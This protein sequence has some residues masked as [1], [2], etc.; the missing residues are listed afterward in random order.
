MSQNSEETGLQKFMNLAQVPHEDIAERIIEEVKSGNVNPVQMMITI[1]RLAKIVELTTDSQ[2]GDKELR[3]IFK[4]SVALALDGGKSVDMFGANLR[5]QATGTY[6][7][8]EPCKDTVLNKLKC[9][10]VEVDEA[11]KK[12][13]NDIKQL[14]PPD[15]TKTLGIRSKKI[16]QEGVPSFTW[17]DD[18]FEEIIYPAVKCAGES[19]IVTFKKQK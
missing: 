1:K 8:F 11:I 16:I 13:E 7:D 10:K 19:V 9:I 15:D 6:Y 17:S 18:E 3:E 12:R 5:I 14:L 2:K 4:N